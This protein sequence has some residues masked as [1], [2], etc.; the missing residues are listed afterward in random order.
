[1]SRH[2]RHGPDSGSGRSRC[3]HLQRADSPA[4]V[5]S[6]RGLRQSPRP[7]PEPT[8]SALH[9]PCAKSWPSS[10]ET[11][12]L[13]ISLSYLDSPMPEASRE[14]PRQPDQVEAHM[15][16]Q[17]LWARIAGPD[18]NL[19]AA[20]ADR[21]RVAERLRA[22]HAEGRLDIDELQER[23]ERCFESKT[24]GELRELVG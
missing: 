3:L 6:S 19:R 5:R 16:N 17:Y 15:T 13:D 11:E 8:L 22:G 24:L 10:P 20:D 21:E 14:A 9:S 4:A 23:L 18:P 2:R 12:Q 7:S 1:G